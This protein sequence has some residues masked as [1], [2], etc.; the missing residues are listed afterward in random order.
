MCALWFETCKKERQIQQKDQDGADRDE[1]GIFESAFAPSSMQGMWIFEIGAF[2]F[3]FSQETV[4]KESGAIRGGAT[5]ENDSRGCCTAF[6][7]EL[8]YGE[9]DSSLGTAKEVQEEEIESAKTC[10]S[11]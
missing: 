8:G 11:R 4:D 10:R 9:R 5:E 6:R 2:G 7:D 1:E 3:E